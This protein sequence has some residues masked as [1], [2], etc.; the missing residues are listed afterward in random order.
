MGPLTRALL[1]EVGLPAESCS[2]EATTKLTHFLNLKTCASSLSVKIQTL[3]ILSQF[4][5]LNGAAGGNKG[6]GTKTNTRE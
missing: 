3:F 6:E 2:L 5:R 1:A 4:F